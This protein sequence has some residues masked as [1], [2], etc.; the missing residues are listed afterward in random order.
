[1][2]P[3]AILR[4]LNEPIPTPFTG[5]LTHAAQF[6]QDLDS[7]MW[8]NRNHPLISTPWTRIDL[9]LAFISGPTTLAWRRSIR[10]GR[11]TEVTTDTLWDDFLESFCE[12]WVHSPE[13]TI[14]AVAPTVQTSTADIPS[15]SLT[16]APTLKHVEDISIVLTADDLPPRCL[17]ETIDLTADDDGTDDWALFA[18]RTFAP[19][20]IS[21][22]ASI[23]DSVKRVD[24][25][26][27]PP[28]SACRSASPIVPVTT[29]DESSDPPLPLIETPDL[30]PTASAA[31]RAEDRPIATPIEADHG[32]TL[33]TSPHASN[34][35]ARKRKHKTDE[36]DDT[37]P[38]KR[39]HAQLAR[40][41]IP[42]PRKYRYVQRRSTISPP[43]VDDSSGLFTPIRL[44]P[45]SPSDRLTTPHHAVSR[46]V[47]PLQL[48]SQSSPADLTANVEHHP[49]NLAFVTPVSHPHLPSHSVSPSPPAEINAISLSSPSPRLPALFSPPLSRAPDL[50]PAYVL[51]SPASVLPLPRASVSRLLPCSPVSAPLSRTSKRS[52]LTHP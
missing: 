20:T 52:H 26:P 48:P 43:P 4:T 27:P 5:D 41:R 30:S 6:L 11:T 31:Q 33:I 35:T 15:P 49:A 21:P 23:L 47:T 10:C 28:R 50:L 16:A 39:I 34:G 14:Y 36:E 22:I 7:L 13:S 42:L 8:K 25:Q 46:D 29:H 45:S 38:G 1:M 19:P 2:L 37:R 24:E 44:C 17:S 3:S 32:E 9:A 51:S 18:P 40:R 12:T